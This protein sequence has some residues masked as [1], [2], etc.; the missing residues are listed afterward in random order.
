MFRLS[1]LL[2]CQCCGWMGPDCTCGRPERRAEVP[3]VAPVAVVTVPVEP[4]EAAA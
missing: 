2:P 1:A 3:A 4:V